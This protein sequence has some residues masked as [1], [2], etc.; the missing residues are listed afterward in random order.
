MAADGLSPEGT[1]LGPLTRVAVWSVPSMTTTPRLD[2]STTRCRSLEIVR[3]PRNEF[4]RNAF[5]RVTNTA[6]PF[7]GVL[8]S[9][10]P[11]RQAPA[12]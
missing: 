3:L 1:I 8:T 2:G 7:H 9:T 5:P 12:A 6:S 4:G 11:P 10:I